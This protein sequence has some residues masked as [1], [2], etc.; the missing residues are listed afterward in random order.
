MIRATRRSSPTI[1]AVSFAA[2]SLAASVA[3][4]TEANPDYQRRFEKT[5]AMKP[6]QRFEIDHSQGAVRITTQKTSEARITAE[7]V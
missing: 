6:G 7:I 3:V 5:V 4:A 2:L 1:A